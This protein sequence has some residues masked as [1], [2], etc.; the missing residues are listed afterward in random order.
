MVKSKILIFILL[1]TL[2][3]QHKDRDKKLIKDF[4]GSLSDPTV[5]T[6]E[7]LLKYM[8]IDRVASDKSAVIDSVL[9]LQI[10]ALRV[11]MENCQ[12]SYPVYN[13]EAAERNGLDGFFEIFG[14][15]LKNVYFLECKS[16]RLI[17]FKISDHHKILSFSTI[18]KGDRRYFL[19]Y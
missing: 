6:R 9:T 11:F 19:E 5:S 4:A 1:L 14:D 16:G 8:E 13:Y 2:S 15:D 18:R 12:E 3:C 7:I 10:E 17:P